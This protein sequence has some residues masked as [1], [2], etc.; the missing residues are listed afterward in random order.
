MPLSGRRL[1]LLRPPKAAAPTWHLASQ[2]DAASFRPKTFRQTAS[3]IESSEELL[4][5]T[6]IPAYVRML[7]RSKPANPTFLA[8][9]L[10]MIRFFTSSLHLELF[11]EGLGIQTLRSLLGPSVALARCVRF[12]QGSGPHAPVIKGNWPYHCRRLPCARC[13]LQERHTS[14]TPLGMSD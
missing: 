2:R 7:L 9:K 10:A 6:N 12:S 14:Y 13:A 5:F 11:G 1:L 4:P 8:G 3:C